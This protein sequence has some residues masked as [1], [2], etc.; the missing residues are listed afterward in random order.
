MPKMFKNEVQLFNNCTLMNNKC[1]SIASHLW[2]VNHKMH[3]FTM[4]VRFSFVH[5]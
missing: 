2:I 1:I 4:I 3:I 5:S